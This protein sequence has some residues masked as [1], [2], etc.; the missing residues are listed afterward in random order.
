MED[1]LPDA[2][3]ELLP[4]DVPLEELSE[5][6]LPDVP[7]PEV[8]PF[9]VLPDEPVPDDEASLDPDVEPSGVPDV[10]EAPLEA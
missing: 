4:D 8:P 9:E 1:G 10:L 7:P 6:V 2:L 3:L 5:P